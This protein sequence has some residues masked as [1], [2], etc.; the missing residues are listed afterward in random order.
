MPYTV[1]AHETSG[2]DRID[3]GG[4]AARHWDVAPDG[5]IWVGYRKQ[6]NFALYY[7]KDGGQTFTWT[8]TS[9]TFNGQVTHGGDFSIFIDIDGYMHVAY[10]KYNAGGNDG[11]TIQN[12]IMY[13]RGTPTG[14]GTGWSWSAE[15]LIAGQD[16]WHCPQVVA[17]RWGTGWL[18]H[19]AFNYNWAGDNRTILYYG[20]VGI[21]SG[22]AL[23]N[24]NNLYLHDVSGAQTYHGHVSMTFRHNGDGKTVQMVN[25]SEQPD[26]YFSWTSSNAI[27]WGRLPYASGAWGNFRFSWDPNWGR[28][29][30]S[31]PYMEGLYQHH[32]WARCI[33][34]AARNQYLVV[35]VFS[36]ASVSVQ[37]TILWEIDGNGPATSAQNQGIL[38]AQGFGQTSNH[39]WSGDAALLPD[40]NL[41][42]C[43]HNGWA[44]PNTN[45]SR[46]IIKRPVSTATARTIEGLEVIEYGH[47][48]AQ[49]SMLSHPS[50]RVLAVW[51][52]GGQSFLA[53]RALGNIN[54]H[55]GG[56]LRLATRYIYN[57]SAW[58]PH[59]KV[60]AV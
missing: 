56:S 21:T 6:G 24:Q 53:D 37:E 18:A 55:S 48:E 33:W 29:Q 50:A 22:G 12:Q 38:R 19:Y 14:G 44:P 60:T 16:Y 30:S 40:G 31:S 32:R 34:D 36:N 4:G 52:R 27:H 1:R 10:T 35:G 2:I 28:V 13:R 43:G 5:T 20:Q 51:N 39:F 41:E 26:I 59:G 3:T 8:S 46:A 47:T 49:V 15:L 17:H 42:I 7:S 58:I 11:R 23:T 54:V 45:L 57:G 25:G 9:Q